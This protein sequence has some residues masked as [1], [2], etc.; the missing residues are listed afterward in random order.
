M[1]NKLPGPVDE[2]FAVDVRGRGCSPCCVACDAPSGRWIDHQYVFRAGRER[3]TQS[4]LLMRRRGAMILL[5]KCMALT[6]QP[7]NIR[8][9]AIAR[10]CE[11]ELT[12]MS[13]SKAPDR[14]PSQ[15]AIAV[16]PMGRL[17]RPEDVAGLAVY[18]A[19]DESSG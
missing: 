11:T 9:N 6:T 19:R 18:L 16:H 8:V 3:S 13:M 17:G 1:P 5:T 14:R 15:R 10:F 2:T 4:C 12:R 7:K